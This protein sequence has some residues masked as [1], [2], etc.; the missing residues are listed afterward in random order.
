MAGITPHNGRYNQFIGTATTYDWLSHSH[1]GVHLG[2]DLESVRY[3][4]R[5]CHS[6]LVTSYERLTPGTPLPPVGSGA[7]LSRPH[8]RP[9][10]VRVNE[11]HDLSSYRQCN[12][13]STIVQASNKGNIK[14]YWLTN[15]WWCHQMETF[16]RYRPF[17][18]EIHRSPLDSP[19]KGQWRGVCC[20]LRSPPEQIAEKTI[21]MSVIWDAIALIMTSV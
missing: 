20:F 19:H 9:R 11:R 6:I 13:A 10:A 14:W 18:R 2:S 3:Y 21:D 1:L 15:P 17:V 8:V 5:H 16:P 12:V 4:E 7:P